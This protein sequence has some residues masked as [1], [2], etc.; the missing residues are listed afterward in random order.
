MDSR[1]INLIAEK[2]GCKS[3]QVANC[4][5]LLEEGDT[6]P[7]ISRYRKEQTGS[8]DDGQ[9]SLVKHLCE[10]YTALAQRKQTVLD[11][12]GKAGKLTPELR[13]QIEQC[14]S[15]TALEDLY[16]PFRPKRRTRATDAAEKGLTPLA[17]L[18]WELK[19][20][21]PSTTAR[22]FLSDGVRNEQEALSGASDILAERFS[23][24]SQLRAIVRKDLRGGK[25]V[26]KQRKG[27]SAKEG[28][29]KWRS[30][31]SFSYP[32]RKIPSH[33]LLA[34]L[35]GE[36][37]G[38]LSVEIDFDASRCSDE[39]FRAFL[40]KRAYPRG[41]LAS[42][43][44]GSLEDSLSR[45]LV[46]SITAEVIREAKVKAD[47]ES[48][49]IFGDNL[50]QLLLEAPLGQKRVLSVDPGFRNG[51]KLAVLD[52]DGSLLDHTVI[53]PHPPQSKKIES[54]QT[55]QGLV[56]KYSIEA[57]ALGNGTAS[58]ETA[59]FLKKIRLPEGCTVH[60]V[61]EDGASIYSASEAARKEFPNEDVTVRG[62]VSIGRRLQ[63][64]LAELVKIDP[65]S[66]GVGQYQHDVDQKMLREKLQEVVEHCVN[67]VGVDLGT[68]SSWLL[69][70]VSGIGPSLAEGIVAYRTE[71]GAFA[72]RQELL[73]VPRLGA[74]TFEQCAGFLRIR[75][76]ANPLDNSAVH[77]ESYPIV[78]RM[79]ADL[80]VS[81]R[82]LVGNASLCA[83]IKPEKYIGGDV[84][85]PTVMD[86]IAELQ[87]PGRDPRES[88]GD[89]H[90]SEE[91]R[92]IAD[93]RE[94]M[95]LPG[96]I[97]NVTAFGA[98]VDVGVHENGLIH[99]SAMGH[100]RNAN[101]ASIVKLHQRV[102]VQVLSVDL[103][104]SRISLKLVS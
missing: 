20:Q 22:G 47:E 79:A 80:G 75:N 21:S 96:I 59:D 102:T 23:E 28:A 37:E 78:D 11:T 87:K 68:A 81:A 34:I 13:E 38:V 55:V 65:K 33:N 97:T 76:A 89:F 36:D 24:Q 6:I 101:P 42:F 103:D 16:L 1:Y 94:G 29:D 10:V 99:V 61:S 60:L 91:V 49:R 92:D 93:L 88:S 41:E 86:I 53:F 57:I 74:K 58:R 52:S 25:L 51:C 45:L 46:P 48:V 3:Y 104:R 19:A 5:M 72:S 2:A 14:V 82:E 15:P 67:L 85:L 12:I 98:F 40:G 90:F 84:G 50:T 69:S 64:P 17:D 83:E 31:S 77:P 18:L 66:L 62:A 71:N 26:S 70:Y 4:I 35:R 56:D 44:K 73:K 8:M 95:T 27:S 43:L 63:D 7:F 32:L 39:L 100:G 30:Y 9:V 54:L